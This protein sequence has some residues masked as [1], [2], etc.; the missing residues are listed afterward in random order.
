MK[1]I[2]LDDEK[3]ILQGM[4]MNCKKV[5]KIDEVIG[6][7]NFKACYNGMEKL[8][9]CERW[10]QS[11]LEMMEKTVDDYINSNEP[12]LAYYMTVSGHFGYSFND[13]SIAYERMDEVI[14][15]ENLSEEA[16][17]YIATQIEL[18]KALELLINK[19]NEKGKLDNTV[20][21]LSADHYPYELDID[22][23]NSLSK[24]ERDEKFE[25]NHNALIIWNNKLESK[26]IDKPCMAPDII[27]TVYNLFGINYESRL[28]TGKDILSTDIGLAVM[29]DH[30]WI[31]DDGVYDTTTGNFK[32]TT[33]KEVD[34]EYINTINRIVSNRLNI[35]KMIIETNYYNYL[36]N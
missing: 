3:I 15:L 5:D 17:G 29:N 13:N 35:S 34:E 4:I 24:N 32:K 25:V 16:K 7:N 21:V 2:C 1:V 18:D 23:I 28:M 9:N 36:F 31:S 19:L 6:F 20:F 27:P 14:N 10:P 12:F 26:E 22:D 11:D 33:D 8:I 30:S